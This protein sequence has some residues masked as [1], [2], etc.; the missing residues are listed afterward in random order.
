MTTPVF[1]EPIPDLGRWF[2]DRDDEVCVLRYDGG[3][4]RTLG[5]E[6]AREVGDLIAERAAR[7]EPPVLMLVVDVLHAELTEVRQM[8]DGRPIADWAPWV[9]AIDLVEHYPS[10]TVVAV[11]RQA[12]CG[13][14]ELS[15][16]A[17]LRVASPTARLGVLETRMGILPGA[18]GTQRLPELVGTGNAALL[19]LTGATVSGNEAHRMGLVQL[20]D[21]DPVGR[22][23]A[24]AEHLA[25]IGPVVL[26]AA[27]GALAAGR[28]RSA[29]GFRAEGKAFL[30]VVGTEPTKRRIDAWLDAQRAGTN[31]ALDT[32]PLP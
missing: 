16:A 2:V 26:G 23:I 5:I 19:V 24:L 12:S 25:T 15:L 20:L 18:G 31:P 8:S 27:K 10:A 13:G 29:D 4:R 22:A 17:D 28:V 30:S 14:L 6:G 3:D 7:D 32:S 1:T 21:D 9:R 11:E